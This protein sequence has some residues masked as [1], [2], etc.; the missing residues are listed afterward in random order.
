MVNYEDSFVFKT[1]QTV[2]AAVFILRCYFI[3]VSSSTNGGAISAVGYQTSNLNISSSIFSK[4]KCLG[5][6]TLKGG[7]IYSRASNL[8]IETSGFSDC[9]ASDTSTVFSN[10]IEST[11]ISSS[12][13]SYENYQ[14]NPCLMFK[15]TIWQSNFSHIINCDNFYIYALY[16][17]I[18]IER[19][20]VDHCCFYNTS[21]SQ[22]YLS[23][24]ENV[25]SSLFQFYTINELYGYALTDCTFID[26]TINKL[27]VYIQTNVYCNNNN[28]QFLITDKIII[29]QFEYSRILKLPTTF[30]LKES[31]N[32][33]PLNLVYTL[34]TIS[35]KD[36][37]FENIGS[38]SLDAGAIIISTEFI[39]PGNLTIECCKFETCIGYSTSAS[40]Q[41]LSPVSA[42]IS[43]IIARNCIGLSNSF[44]SYIAT[45]RSKYPSIL[46]RISIDSC[47]GDF[48]ADNKYTFGIMRGFFDMIYTITG[49]NISNSKT[50]AETSSIID[51][52]ISYCQIA[53]CAT[54]SR[55]I[56]W[57]FHNYNFKEIQYLNI[58]NVALETRASHFNSYP[59]DIIYKN[60]QFINT[61]IPND[62]LN[63]KVYVDCCFMNE[64]ITSQCK[65]NDINANLEVSCEYFKEN[66]K[67][68]T[69]KPFKIPTKWIIT[70]CVSI[71]VLIAVIGFVVYRRLCVPL[72]RLEKRKE[73]E[74]NILNDFG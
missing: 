26:G 8:F 9:Y 33:I 67:T 51:Y 73:L 2:D 43:K 11:K 54:T 45:Q 18:Q 58:L 17:N 4:C 59:S 23:K 61:L 34:E 29:P 19:N 5:P 57:I 10:A 41:I 62:Y 24:Y 12:A 25:T 40:I 15:L 46:E 38:K 65:L 31:V 52:K 55:A 53:N 22:S 50:L 42:S 64:T 21:A 13:F 35:I 70:V 6:Q 44:L 20:L 39:N 69:P 71:A 63:T 3:S 36:C 37:I 28:S 47:P 27:S 30:L 1:L 72:K 32:T 48:I 74:Q 56:E 66:D 16:E 68:V 49:V 60:C 14:T 7:A